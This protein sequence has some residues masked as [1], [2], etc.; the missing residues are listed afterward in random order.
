MTDLPYLLHLETPQEEPLARPFDVR[1]WIVARE[2]ITAVGHGGEVDEWLALQDRPDVRETHPEW[3]HAVGFSGQLGDAALVGDSLR[4]R[5]KLTDTTHEHQVAISP[6]HPPPDHLQVRQVGSVWGNNFYPAGRKM[7]DQIA[8]TFAGVDHPLTTADRVL[9]FGCGCGRVL[10]SFGEVQHTG[11]IWGCDIDAESIAWN[12]TN[13]AHL[14]Q[15]V[16]NPEM[17][18]SQFE[19]GFFNAIYS[20]SVFTH[21]PE[22]MQTA[23]AEEMHRILAPGG[24]LVASIH[25]ER[26]WSQDPAV[27]A[28]VTEK[29]FAYRT[30]QITKGLPAFYM[31]AYHSIEYI[32]REWSQ[33]FDVLAHHPSYIDG[34][35]DAVVL[36]RRAD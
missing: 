4:L 7:F 27:A 14:G 35:H 34:A 24:V 15:Y 18:P 8:D 30:G 10:R 16:T 6:I 23:W 28:E 11:E 12:Q 5:V 19:S 26:Y 2:P 25:G 33:W 36:R 29:G 20:V 3:P 22:P 13:L 32:Q 1:G 17:P 31:V 9:D 21:L